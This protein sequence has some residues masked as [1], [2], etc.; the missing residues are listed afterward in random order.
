M[1]SS[2]FKCRLSGKN[3][4]WVLN[5]NFNTSLNKASTICGESW[6]AWLFTYHRDST[7]N[8]YKQCTAPIDEYRSDQGRREIKG[9][10]EGAVQNPSENS[11]RISVEAKI[12]LE[13]RVRSKSRDE[14]IFFYPD[15]QETIVASLTPSDWSVTFPNKRISFVRPFSFFYFIFLYFTHFCKYICC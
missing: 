1:G 5:L 8:L 14:Q 15:N 9:N 4:R 10:R 13:L 3:Q 2:Y 6:S 12:S 11:S 7:P